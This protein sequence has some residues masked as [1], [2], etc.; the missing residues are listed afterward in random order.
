V[1]LVVYGDQSSKQIWKPGMEAGNVTARASEEEYMSRWLEYFTA[2]LNQPAEI[3]DS[4]HEYL[5]K[6]CIVREDL[7]RPFTEDQVYSA[8]DW[9]LS[10]LQRQ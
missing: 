5:P 7:A 9:T 10:P 6:Q 1:I 3:S 2:L 4:L 8:F